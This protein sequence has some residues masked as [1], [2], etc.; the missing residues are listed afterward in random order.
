MARYKP[1]VQA[2][3]C[4]ILFVATVASAQTV[5]PLV[6]FDGSNGN[7]PY[8]PLAQALNGDLYGITTYAGGPSGAGTVFKTSATGALTTLYNFTGGGDGGTPA[9]YGFFYRELHPGES[10]EVCN[11]SSENPY[12]PSKAI[13][14]EPSKEDAS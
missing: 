10:Y 1:P 4:L 6:S 9:A 3:V 8:G 11:Y 12:S 5:T 7:E 2:G 14:R 13:S